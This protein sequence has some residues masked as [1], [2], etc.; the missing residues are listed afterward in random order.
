MYKYLL[1]LIF[2]AIPAF[3]QTNVG[4]QLVN[5]APSGAVSCRAQPRMLVSGTT[6]GTLYTPQGTSPSCTW[7]VVANGSGVTNYWTKTS[8]DINNNNTGNV[9]IGCAP[10]SGE[11]LDIC[12]AQTLQTAT[13]N[14]FAYHWES[15]KRGN[16][17]GATNAVATGSEIGGFTAA[18]WNGS[19]YTVTTGGFL[20]VACE[21]WTLTA[22]CTRMQ[23][24]T[25]PAGTSGDQY[26]MALTGPGDL[27]LLSGRVLGLSSSSSDPTQI[28]TAFSRLGANRFAFGNGTPGNA[29]A[30]IDVGSCI[31]CNSTNQNI[32]TI[33]YNF[34]GGGSALSGTITRCVR[35]PYAG[36]IT[37]WYIDADQSGSATFGVR[38]VAF[39]S[40]TGSAGYSGYTDVTGGGTAPVLSSAVTATFANLTS[41]ATAVTAKEYCMQLSSPAT[42]TWI[43]VYLI[44]S[45]S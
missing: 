19:A 21:N 27:G 3:A 4:I 30:E 14:P 28:D 38:S 16:N 37:G 12:G 36:T 1:A 42:V 7:G 23:F 32:R 24:Y 8:N 44:V 39:A 10:T 31:G 17:G 41:W 11:K 40:Y 34:D 2:L 20:T 33:G 22:N 29:T 25:T 43:N 6:A 13:A 9:G 26:S 45:A 18:G 5:T 15:F 35:V